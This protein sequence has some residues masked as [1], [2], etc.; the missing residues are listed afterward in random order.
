MRSYDNK[1]ARKNPEKLR[2]KRDWHLR[3]P[4]K[5]AASDKKCRLKRYGL[6]SEEYDARFKKQGGVC[7]ICKKKEVST[8]DGKT[9]VLAVDHDHATGAVRGLLCT[10]CN[11]GLAMFRD[12]LRLLVLAGRYLSPSV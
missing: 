6:T 4:E 5:A 2:V 3:N 8:R 9:K 11:T 12:D 7:A 10:H 1:W